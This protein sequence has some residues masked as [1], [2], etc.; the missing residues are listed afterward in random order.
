M[1]G[2]SHPNAYTCEVGLGPL[3]RHDLYSMGC[4]PTSILLHLG[5]SNKV[6]GR[7]VAQMKSV[8]EW[9]S[10]H[11]LVKCDPTAISGRA[12][13]PPTRRG[14]TGKKRSRGRAPLAAKLLHVDGPR[15]LQLSRVTPR[16]VIMLPL[17]H[18][19]STVVC[20]NCCLSAMNCLPALLH[21]SVIGTV[22]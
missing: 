12:E 4:L 15:L 2:T 17:I 9:Q 18:G 21:Y 8:G 10:C 19:D 13:R 14:I 11:F 7:S 22:V 1:V 20:H 16:K 3:H 6:H 5:C